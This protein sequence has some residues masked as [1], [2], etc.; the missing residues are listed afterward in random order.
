MATLDRIME[1][2]K[3]GISDT[4]ITT[5]L[6]NEGIPAADISN[7]LNQAKIKNAVSPPETMPQGPGG[8]QVSIMQGNNPNQASTNQNLQ[9]SM[10]QKSQ[11]PI[12]TEAPK[13]ATPQAPMPQGQM[14]QAPMP[15]QAQMPQAPAQAPPQAP[16]PQAGLPPA[17]M[18]TEAPMPQNPEVYPNEEE[19]DPYYAQGQQAYAEQDYYPQEGLGTDTI[20]EIAEQV[21]IEK[22]NEYK[23]KTGDIVNFKNRMKEKVNDMD[24]RLK[25]IENSIDKL[26][27][28]VIGK[29]GE[30]TENSSLIHKDLDNLHGTVKK[31]MDPL[32]DNI[33]A[34]KKMSK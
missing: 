28:A 25:R 7:S 6:T 18:P 9:A 17:P 22:I 34:L 8:M 27:H 11:V 2:Q 4:E 13:E 19:V 29:V 14:P 5:Q 31:L 33:N 16:M 30:F 15:P 1:M 21:A 10:T 32:V 3:N 12:P 26:Q 23:E 24:E 20:S